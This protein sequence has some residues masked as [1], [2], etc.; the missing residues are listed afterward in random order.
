MIKTLSPRSSSRFPALLIV[1]ALLPVLCVRLDAAEESTPVPLAASGMVAEGVGIFV[2]KGLDAAHLPPSLALSAPVA[3]TAPLAQDWRIRPVF[4]RDGACFQASVRVPEGTDLYGGGEVTGPLRRN[5]QSI[6][7]WNTDNFMYAKKRGK[8][9]YQSHPW[10]M[11]VRP[12]GTAFG[13]LFDST[14]KAD[15]SCGDDILFRSRGPAFPVLVIDRESPRAVLQSLAGLIG[16][17]PLPPLWTLGYHQCRWSYNPDSRVREIAGEFRKRRIP[18]DVLWMDIDYMDGFRIFTFDKA[19]FP[20][21]SKLNDDLHAQGFH[22]IWMIDPGVKADP[23]YGIYDSGRKGNVFVRNAAGKEYKGK[24]WPGLCAFPDFTRPEVRSWWGDLY[25]AYMA[26]GIDGVWNDMNEPSVFNGPGGTMPVTNRHDGGGDLPPGPHLQYHNVYGLLMTMA[27]REGIRQANPSKRPFVLTRS[28]FLGGQ[29]YAATWTGDNASTPEHM[30]LSVPMSITLGLSGQPFNGPDLGGFMKKLTPDLYAQW[31]G[32]GTFFPFCRGHA[33][34]GMNDKEPWAF[35]PAVEKTARTA[36][37]RRYRLL[38]YL[39]T[40]F[41]ASSHDGLPVMR[42]V[43]LADPKDTALRSEQQVFL[44]GGDLLVE[45]RWARN[46]RLPKG[47]WPE[48]SLIP[49]DLEDP[50]QARLR[51]RPGSIIPLGRVVQNTTEQSLDPL[52]LLVCPDADGNAEG[53]LYEDA[54]EGLGYQNGDFRRT[55][56]RASTE[57]GKVAVRVASSEGNREPS[58]KDFVTEVVGKSHAAGPSVP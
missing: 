55:T 15:L 24:V 5:G 32:F 39:Y 40:L 52:T 26:T 48:V 28:N 25:K 2:P 56:F 51:I 20:D 58:W 47:D 17:I 38:P 6:T 21:P 45:P 50:N 54:G 4:S 12:D 16:T 30:R 18:C 53:T 37:E 14:W 36:I 29:R 1:A 49:G 9:L 3:I 44:L 22:S 27:S 34:K 33:A 23:A 41:E 46:A 42:P 8:R 10:I 19:Q 11:G 13:V 35:G 31:I 7:L 43:F 57:N